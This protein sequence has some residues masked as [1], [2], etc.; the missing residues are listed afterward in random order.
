MVSRYSNATALALVREFLARD[1]RGGQISSREYP[2][3]V[4]TGP[5]EIGKSALLAELQGHLERWVPYS[6][7]DCDRFNG[8]AREL[9]ALLA[10]DLNRG[11]DEYGALPFPRLITGQL[12]IAAQLDR[13]DREVARSQVSRVLEEYKRTGQMLR[14]ALTELIDGVV[15]TL[16]GVPAVQQTGPFG[17]AVEDMVARFGPRLILGG[18]AA[19]RRGRRLILGRGQEWWGH[20]D[21]GLRRSPLDALVDLNQMAAGGTNAQDLAEWLW[22]AFLA[23]L[24]DSF[25]SSRRASRRTLNGVIMLDNV[26]GTAGEKL[27]AELVEARRNRIAF[28]PGEPDPLTVIATS[29]GSLAE[30]VC[31]PDRAGIVPLGEASYAGYLRRCGTPTGRDWYPVRL[32]ELTENEVTN[33]VA[34]LELPVGR[35][36]MVSSAVYRFTSGH[37]GSVRILLDAIAEHPDHPADLL[38]ILNSKETGPGGVLPRTVEKALRDHL[39]AGVSDESD[40][41][42]L[43]TCAAAR[44]KEAALHLA[45]DSGLLTGMRGEDSVIFAPELWR[46]GEGSGSAVL[47]PVLARLL[48]RRL[49]ERAGSDPASWSAVHSWLRNRCAEVGDHEGELYHALAVGDLEHVA[50]RFT[51]LLKDT[52]AQSWLRLLAAVTQ[53]PNHLDHQ[54][55]VADQIAGLTAWARQRQELSAHVG[56]LITACW[57]DADPMSDQHRLGLWREQ[58]ADLDQIAPDSNGIAVLRERANAI[59]AAVAGLR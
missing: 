6:R 13:G 23:D 57:I 53:A 58:A 20:Q 45:E 46:A 33:M 19:T 21:R 3:I 14:T 12:A 41:A 47:H 40:G 35:R 42:D 48:N 44:D 29:R 28:S 1:E 34:A 15:T 50:L 32:P 17:V 30:G 22:G 27:L 25:Q 18:L 59:R 16:G 8:G 2:I 38:A 10:F 39:L 51:A 52:D 11:S 31:G 4:F 55:P 7:I 36:R 49:A 9:L 37:P 43:V 5:R 56:R 24:R 26:D 54:L